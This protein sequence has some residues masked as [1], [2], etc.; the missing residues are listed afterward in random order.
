MSASFPCPGRRQRDSRAKIVSE[1]IARET[2][3][4]TDESNLYIE[5]GERFCRARNG[6]A[7]PTKNMRAAM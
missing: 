6:Q 4:H 3:L 2:R 7:Q 1:N 5:V